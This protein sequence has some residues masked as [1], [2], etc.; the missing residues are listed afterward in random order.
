MQLRLEAAILQLDSQR[1]YFERQ[2][3]NLSTHMNMQSQA[4]SITLHS[5]SGASVRSGVCG[6]ARTDLPPL[7]LPRPPPPASVHSLASLAHSTTTSSGDAYDQLLP[8]PAATANYAVVDESVVARD[9]IF[10]TKE[11]PSL[12]CTCKP[13]AIPGW[14]VMFVGRTKARS[15]SAYKCL[16]VYT[17][18]EIAAMPPDARAVVRGYDIMM[19]GHLLAVIDDSVTNEDAAFVRTKIAD[20]ETA[21]PGTVASS[22]RVIWRIID[23]VIK[24]KHGSELKNL[25]SELKKAFFSMQQTPLK[26]KLAAARLKTLRA[27]LPE[28]SRGGERK[29]LKALLKKFP[30]ELADDA[31]RFKRK[32]NE[33]EVRLMPYEW[34]YEQLTAILASLIGDASSIAEANA[35]DTPRNRGGAIGTAE[36]EGCLNCGMTNHTTKRCMT[37]PCGFCGMRFC[38]GIRKRGPTPGCLVKKIIDGGE[39]KDSDI[40]GL[41]GKPLNTYLVGQIKEKADALKSKRKGNETHTASVQ[42]PPPQDLDE[43]DY[44]GESDCCELLDVCC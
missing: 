40:I 11:I 38:F 17:D 30:A 28:G 15:A 12:K 2:I 16:C 26:V 1:E 37:Q 3:A 29:L 25:E 44:V 18:A 5:A 13:D 20:R 6:A 35:A 39:L 10:S 21:S 43:D 23:E 19:A 42:T 9:D 33:C 4:P 31:E 41:N 14:Q 34:T 27:Q 32:M 7:D 24:P 36:F 8:E 22:G